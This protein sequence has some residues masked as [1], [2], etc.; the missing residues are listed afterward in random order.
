MHLQKPT[1]ASGFTP[2]QRHARHGCTGTQLAPGSAQ[3][4]IPP[5]SLLAQTLCKIREDEE[6]VLLVAP[7]WPNRGGP[8]PGSRELKLNHGQSIPGLIGN[9]DINIV[10]KLILKRSSIMS[11]ITLLR[12]IPVC[13]NISA[14]WFSCV[15]PL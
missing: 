7:Y 13:F 6:Q 3:I 14:L 15:L 2:Y 10:L 1:I 12:S 9:V 11:R 8:G 4:C 5:V